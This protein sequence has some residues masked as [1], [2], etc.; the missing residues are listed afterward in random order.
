MKESRRGKPKLSLLIVIFFNGF[1][2]N[3]SFVIS[4]IE[5]R[6]KKKKKNFLLIFFSP[7]PQSQFIAFS[8]IVQSGI[9]EPTQKKNAKYSW[10][11]LLFSLFHTLWFIINIKHQ[12]S[13]LLFIETYIHYFNIQILL[14]FPFWLISTGWFSRK[15]CYYW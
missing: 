15:E 11:S 2:K 12:L 13:R 3:L 6:Q 7:V 9:C 8:F 5:Y 14:W 4:Q 1:S 10:R